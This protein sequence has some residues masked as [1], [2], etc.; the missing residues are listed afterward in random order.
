M[1]EVSERAG[2]AGNHQWGLDAGDH[3]YWNPYDGY[4]H[5]GEREEDEE[6]TRVSLLYS[7]LYLKL[8]TG[9]SNRSETITLKTLPSQ[10]LKLNLALSRI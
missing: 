1:F 2:I 8:F 3:Q 7:R 10:F 9:L 4:W 6:E 5:T